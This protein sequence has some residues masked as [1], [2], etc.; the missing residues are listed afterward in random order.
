MTTEECG[1]KT[2]RIVWVSCVIRSVSILRTARAVEFALVLS[3]SCLVEPRLIPVPFID[4]RSSPR[5]PF[6]SRLDFRGNFRKLSKIK[7][8]YR[9]VWTTR[10]TAAAIVYRHIIPRTPELFTK[11]VRNHCSLSTGTDRTFESLCNETLIGVC[12]SFPLSVVRTRLVFNTSNNN[13]SLSHQGHTKSYK[14]S[15]VRLRLGTFPRRKFS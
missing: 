1:T 13:K 7:I 2:I 12:D 9:V 4:R 14:A 5:L 10:V 11:Q 6:S 15:I 3:G 8:S